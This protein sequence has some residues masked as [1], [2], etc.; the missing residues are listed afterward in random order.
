MSLWPFPI[1]EVD[2]TT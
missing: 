2:A 1:F